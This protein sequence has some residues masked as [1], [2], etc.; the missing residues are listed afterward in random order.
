MMDDHNANILLFIDDIKQ[1]VAS[2]NTPINF[3]LNTEKL[4][5]G[6]HKLKIVSQSVEKKQGIKEISFIVRNGPSID[7]EGLHENQIVDGTIP[8][9]I[10][11]YPNENQKKFIITGSETPKSIP[12]W[13][14][15]ILIGFLG[16]ATYYTISNFNI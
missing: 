7:V 14:W 11:S 9:M 3:V 15:V 5:D 2:L 1:P 8:L 4:T 16:W 13:F 12:S 10:N 6:K